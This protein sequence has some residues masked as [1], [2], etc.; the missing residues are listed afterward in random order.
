MDGRLILE[1]AVFA[2][3][4]D[5]RYVGRVIVGLPMIALYVHVRMSDEV[6]A[7]WDR[8]F[9]QAAVPHICFRSFFMNNIM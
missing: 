3:C 8:H 9:D 4:R 2:S 7:F 5:T 6:L 1:A